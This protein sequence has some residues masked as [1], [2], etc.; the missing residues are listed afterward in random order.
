MKEQSYNRQLEL[1]IYNKLSKAGYECCDG[2]GTIV[3]QYGKIYTN[4]QAYQNYSHIAYI[5]RLKYKR[6]YGEEIR[7]KSIT[8]EQYDVL[9]EYVNWV[10]DDSIEEKKEVENE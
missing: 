1:Y 8:K 3:G 2:I 7:N 6:K 5:I 4:P 9:I 10:F